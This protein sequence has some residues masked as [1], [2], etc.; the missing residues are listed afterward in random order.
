[1]DTKQELQAVIGGRYYPEG[2][3]YVLN[4]ADVRRLPGSAIKPLVV[5]APAVEMGNITPVSFIDDEP[6]SFGNYS[7]SNYGG[8]L[9]GI[10]TVRTAL[11]KSINIPAVK[12][13]HEIGINNGQA[14]AEKWASTY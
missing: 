4:R 1:M 12:I 2:Q 11:A 7:P 6:V 14:I 3:R 10:V 8:R 5:Y 9:Y 13:L